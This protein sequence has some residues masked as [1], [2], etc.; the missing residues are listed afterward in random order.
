MHER[1]IGPD[2]RAR[3]ASFEVDEEP[4]EVLLGDV[5]VYG[6][7]QQPEPTPAGGRHE[8]GFEMRRGIEAPE[9]GDG[10]GHELQC[11]FEVRA[12]LAL[13]EMSLEISGVARLELAVEVGAQA[14]ADVVTT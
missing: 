4:I 3:W 8:I 9:G 2:S 5:S 10:F 14:L 6:R 13:R 7:H 11:V 1:K 12:L